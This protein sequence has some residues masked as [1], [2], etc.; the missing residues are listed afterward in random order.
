[1][2]RHSP[3]HL[4]SCASFSVSFCPRTPLPSSRATRGRRCLA[5]PRRVAVAIRS[6]TRWSIWLRGASPREQ[7]LPLT[8]LGRCT[9]VI[10]VSIVQSA[11]FG[12]ACLRVSTT[13]DL[14][15]QD[16]A[17]GPTPDLS[18]LWRHARDSF[19]SSAAFRCVSPS[20]NR[21]AAESTRPALTSS[22]A[23]CAAFCSAC[24]QIN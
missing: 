16:G 13:V 22:S 15:T 20:E 11:R 4:L 18:R 7:C 21:S 10:A 2:L 14:A 1:M 6:C 9:A 12:C 23:A 19:G 8:C 3:S 17:D 5:I 24:E